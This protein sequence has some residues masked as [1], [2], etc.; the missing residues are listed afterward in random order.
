MTAVVLRVVVAAVLLLAF[1]VQRSRAHPGRRP[2]VRDGRSPRAHGVGYLAGGGYVA[3]AADGG[4]WGGGGFDG[5]G[6]GGGDGGGGG[7]C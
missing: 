3:G 1:G 6:G 4:G 2:A 7:G 5:G